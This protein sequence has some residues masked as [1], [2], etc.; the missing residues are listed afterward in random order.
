LCDL[1]GKSRKEAARQLGWAEG[2]LS[3]RLARARCLLAKRLAR[4]GLALTAGAPALAL[5]ERG[6]AGGPAAPAGLPGNGAPATPAGGAR[7]GVVPAKVAAL[8]E[9]VLRAMMMTKLKAAAAVVLLLAGIGIGAGTLARQTWAADGPQCSERAAAPSE[10]AP[11]TPPYIIEPPDV[12]RVEHTGTG[13]LMLGVG[14]NSDAGRTGS[15]GLNGEHLVRPDGS[16]GLGNLGEVMV[17]GLTVE[18]AKEAIARHLAK[19]LD[20][21]RGNKLKVEV[22]ASNS[23]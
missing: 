23:K 21:F 20:D 17:T 6:R 3:G 7:A 18:Q 11:A 12:L 14:V 9:G 19:K 15:I 22:A 8:T 10:P 16:I 13:S 5:T 2:T 4:H 1:E